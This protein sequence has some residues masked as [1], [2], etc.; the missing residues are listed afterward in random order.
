MSFLFELFYKIIGVSHSVKTTVDTSI[1]VILFLGIIDLILMTCIQ[2]SLSKF[3]LD[4]IANVFTISQKSKAEPQFQD[5]ISSTFYDPRKKFVHFT[6]DTLSKL[7]LWAWFY[8]LKHKV[9]GSNGSSIWTGHSN[10]FWKII[11]M[12]KLNLA[13]FLM[14]ASMAS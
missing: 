11:S 13:L 5:I 2:N 7:A 14:L 3:L 10:L 12:M 9:S 1:S 4:I 8:G 6:L